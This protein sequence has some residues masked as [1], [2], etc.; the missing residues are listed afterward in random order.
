L[1]DPNNLPPYVTRIKYTE[2]AMDY[3]ATRK[4]AKAIGATHYFTG[5]PCVRGHVAL[6]KTK[7][8]C[9][10]CLKEDWAVDNARRAQLPKSEAAKAAGRRYYEQNRELVKARAAER[11]AA[12]KR[13][14]RKVWKQ[15]HPE[16][17]QASANAWKRRARH[18][19]PNW[20]TSEQKQQIRALYLAARDLTRR[21]K[22]KH[23]VDHIVPLRS[24]EVCGLHV[25]WNLQILTHVDN[26]AKSNKLLP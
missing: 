4:E 9:V 16:L 12:T 13:A 26:C 25:P 8:A 24:T 10:E 20:L 2:G 7:G 22:V 1:L 15:N 6:R 14:Y 19:T 5:E 23:V 11:P 17:V 18:A 3:P 21:T